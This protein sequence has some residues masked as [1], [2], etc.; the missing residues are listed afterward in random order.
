MR[1]RDWWV[2]GWWLPVVVSAAELRGVVEWERRPV[3]EAVVYLDVVVTQSVSK[4]GPVVVE[5]HQRQLQPRVSV[6]TCGGELLLQNGDPTLHVV[7]VEMFDR[8]RNPTLLAR[9]AMPYAGYEKRLPLPMCREPVLLRISGENG[10]ERERAYVAVLPHRWAAVTDHKGAFQLPAVPRGRWRLGVWHE[11]I[12][13]H[14]EMVTVNG[15]RSVT[16]HLPTAA[17]P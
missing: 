17:K 5:F 7:R 15:N 4:A 16:I 3:A 1:R 13:T 11:R 8:E 2:L 9:L 6:A 10:A 12:G 14:V